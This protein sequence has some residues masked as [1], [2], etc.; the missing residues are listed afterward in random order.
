[1]FIF[2]IFAK[3]V[4]FLLLRKNKEVVMYLIVG[5]LTTLIS[6]V[7]YY[8]CTSLFFNPKYA[9]NIQISAVI[10][11]IVS[12]TFAYVANKTFVFDSKNTVAKEFV[13]FISSRIG[14][15]LV[16]ML[17]MFIFASVLQFNDMIVKVFVEI[18]VIIANYLLSK[19]L[20]FK[21]S[22]KI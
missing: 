12:V 4:F 8:L 5:A 22:G 13:R 16:D 20:V 2:E 19:L 1:L 14:T 11:W 9:L 15:L 21:E 18:V 6:I 10:S 7:T 17:L 3:K